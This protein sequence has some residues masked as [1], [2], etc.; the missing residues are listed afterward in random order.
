MRLTKREYIANQYRVVYE[1]HDVNRAIY[2]LG[3]YEDI[4]EELGID[5]TTLFK[6]LK[7]GYWYKKNNNIVCAKSTI[8]HTYM[9]CLYLCD[10]GWYINTNDM[11]DYTIDIALKDYGK[12][13][14]LTKEELE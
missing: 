2:K 9:H 3:K 6:A 13:W 12:T 14:A 1:T 5:L 11:Y 10:N 8:G 4:E 7:N